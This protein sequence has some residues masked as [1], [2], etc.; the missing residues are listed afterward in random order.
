V[1][2]A[3]PFDDSLD[4]LSSVGRFAHDDCRTVAYVD[5]LVGN[6]RGDRDRVTD[7]ESCGSGV[8]F[9][10]SHSAYESR[11]E[12][13]QMNLLKLLARVEHDC[14]HRFLLESSDL[15]TAIILVVAA[16]AEGL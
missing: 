12:R 15:V 1:P 9:Q 5:E 4:F 2:L 8:N 13:F 3:A 6:I 10:Y 11:C 16:A 7:D 14:R